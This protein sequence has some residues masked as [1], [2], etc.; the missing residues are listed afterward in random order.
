MF[1][2]K[3]KKVINENIKNTE[4]LLIENS[5]L[6]LDRLLKKYETSQE[7][8]SITDIDDKLE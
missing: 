2:K 5:K 6:K 3:S 1:N 8:I 7:G 4:N